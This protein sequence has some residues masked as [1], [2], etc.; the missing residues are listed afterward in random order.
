MATPLRKTLLG[1]NVNRNFR[2]P[3]VRKSPRPFTYPWVGNPLPECLSLWRYV[4]CGNHLWR[5][6]F[7]SSFYFL[8]LFFVQNTPW[9]AMG[10]NGNKKSI[11]AY[12]TACGAVID[13]SPIKKSPIRE[14]QT[15]GCFDFESR[16]N[17]FAECGDRRDCDV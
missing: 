5:P 10:M 16:R 7:V 11:T 4:V 13:F 6:F 2:R 1:Q 17:L 15:G 12:R 8:F 3:T 9:L 14:V